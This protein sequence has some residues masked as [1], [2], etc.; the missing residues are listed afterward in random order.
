MQL[1][2]SSVVSLFLAGLLALQS[3]G[4]QQPEESYNINESVA[5]L[6]PK[7]H[8]AVH[9]KEGNTL[10]GR[11]ANR[12][13]SGFVLK[14]DKGAVAQKISYQQVQNVEQLQ[15]PRSNKKRIIFGVVTGILVAAAIVAI[16][17]KNHPLGANDTF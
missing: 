3:A 9:L 16:H 4:A 12:S 6:P 15:T 11:L 7:A 10:R 5:K 14:L 2:I 1:R 8:V 13:D 17:A